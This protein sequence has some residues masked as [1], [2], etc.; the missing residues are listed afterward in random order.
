MISSVLQ[1]RGPQSRQML[2]FENPFHH[3]RHKCRK[4]GHRSGGILVYLKKHIAQGVK[5]IPKPH[6]VLLL[7]MFDKEYFSLGKD[8]FL[9]V[10][11]ISPASGQSTCT[12]FL[13]LERDIA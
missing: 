13:K 7:V 2:R 6:D 5:E 12:S 11:Y 4:K 9:C 1:K 3:F 8:L 10:A